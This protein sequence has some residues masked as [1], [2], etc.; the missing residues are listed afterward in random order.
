MPLLTAVFGLILIALGAVAYTVFGGEDPSITALI[1]S[2][3]GVVF[4]ALGVAAFST[5]IRKHAMHGAAA[6]GLLAV[7]GSARGLP[8]LPALLR[9][10]EL[11]S[12]AA[13]VVV[14]SIMCALSA[15]FVV[16]CVLS[17]IRARKASAAARG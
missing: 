12:P 16:A 6:L 8:A 3:F 2:F 14:Q 5:G 13:A 15:A 17:F 1:P 9:G 11:D 10:D 4:L 7:I